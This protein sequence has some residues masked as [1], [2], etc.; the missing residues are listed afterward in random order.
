MKIYIAET[1]SNRIAQA[2]KELMKQLNPEIHLPTQP[3][4]TEIIQ[5]GNT[6]LFLAEETENAE[7][8]VGTLTLVI[9]KTPSGSKAQIEDVVV[10]QVSRGKGVGKQL[11]HAAIDY[12]RQAG[13]SKIDLTSSPHRI[14]ANHLYQKFGFEKRTTNIYRLN[15]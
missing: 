13:I 14:Q 4:L 8:I 7:E 11:M 9:I 6:K 1:F 3:E 2:F 15:L 5:S 10:S 12:A